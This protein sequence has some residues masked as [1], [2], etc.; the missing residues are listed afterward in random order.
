MDEHELIYDWNGR[1][2]VRLDHRAGRPQRRDAARRPPVAVGDRPVDRDQAPPAAPHGRPGHRRG[3][4]R[5]ARAPGRAWWSRCGRLATEIRDHKLPIAPNCAARTVIARHRADRPDLRRRSGIPIEAATFIGSSPI[6][7]Y[8]EDWTLDRMLQATEEA[9]TFAVQ[10][11]LPV[12][13]V[14]EDTTRA[15]PETLKALYGTR[16]RLR[17]AARICLADTVGHATPDGVQGV[18][19]LRQATRSS[20]TRRRREDRLARPPRPRP[21]ARSTAS[22]RSRPAS[23]ACTRRRSAS[24]SGSATPRWIC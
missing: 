18:G 15:A 10:H 2:A 6:R 13:Y 19:E 5:P 24:A 21:G 14:T 11:G 1:R 20:S 9:V 16:H 17:R 7:Q 8:A 12:M 22:R 3:R 4:H 23:I